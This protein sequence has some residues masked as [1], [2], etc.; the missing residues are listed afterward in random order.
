MKHI[1]SLT[2]P[3]TGSMTML[4][5]HYEQKTQKKEPNSQGR[6]NAERFKQLVNEEQ[7]KASGGFGHSCMGSDVWKGNFAQSTQITPT[8]GTRWFL[9]SSHLI[10]KPYRSIHEY[11]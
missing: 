1:R 10:R 2:C 5:G 3:A 4:S 8:H 7:V 6:Q 9:W 11:V